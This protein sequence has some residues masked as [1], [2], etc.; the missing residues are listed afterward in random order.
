MWPFLVEQA[1]RRAA[2]AIAQRGRRRP[3]QHGRRVTGNM[4]DAV[5]TGDIYAHCGHGGEDLRPVP[6]ADEHFLEAI[7]NMAGLMTGQN[8]CSPSHA[9]AY[10]ECRF[11]GPVTA[12][13]AD[14]CMQRAVA[15]LDEIVEVTP[16]QRLIP[17]RSVTQ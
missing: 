16:Q 5:A 6:L 1:K 2:A 9:Q 12:D 11:V 7:E 13:I 14:Q 17:A 10:P 8:Q 15:Q 4:Y 3:E